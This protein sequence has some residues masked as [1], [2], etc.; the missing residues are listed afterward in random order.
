MEEEA[1]VEL[2]PAEPTIAPAR[3]KHQLPGFEPE[4]ELEPEPSQLTGRGESGAALSQQVDGAEQK[5][6]EREP[7]VAEGVPPARAS[8]PPVGASIAGRARTAGQSERRVAALEEAL[9]RQVDAS[10]R[11]E[12]VLKKQH[13]VALL[14]Q[15]AHHSAELARRDDQIARLQNAVQTL[16]QQHKH[17]DGDILRLRRQVE[18]QTAKAGA[19]DRAQAPADAVEPVAASGTIVSPRSRWSAPRR[20]LTIAVF[21][22]VSSAFL[23]A[24]PGGTH[25][26]HTAVAT[27]TFRELLVALGEGVAASYAGWHATMLAVLSLV[28]ACGLVGP[29]VFR[30]RTHNSCCASRIKRE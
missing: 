27:L 22:V 25:T 3:A 10:E 8:P 14:G 13:H 18:R 9:Q 19:R 17:K 5:Q 12:Q 2:L 7:E 15:K 20:L 21:V 11:R 30:R 23:I 28:A 6:L 29:R 24:V 4:P 16:Q 26:L 1:E